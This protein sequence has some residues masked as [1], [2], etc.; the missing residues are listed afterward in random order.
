MTS[1]LLN[2]TLIAVF[3]VTCLGGAAFVLWIFLLI[4]DFI[5]RKKHPYW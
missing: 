1:T 3:I 5:R 4:G 2:A